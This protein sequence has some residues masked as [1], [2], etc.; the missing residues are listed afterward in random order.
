[1]SAEARPEL[2]GTNRGDLNAQRAARPSAARLAPTVAV[3]LAA[4]MVYALA[5][6]PLGGPLEPGF[7]PWWSFVVVFFAAEL[8]T[9]AGAGRVELAALNPHDAAIVLAFFF[10]S[11]SGLFAA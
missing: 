3:G 1:M 8:F 7:V 9:L 2:F 6:R 4:A 5:V 11:P 10:V